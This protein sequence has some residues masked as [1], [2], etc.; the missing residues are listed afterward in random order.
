MQR[1]SASRSRRVEKRSR[2]SPLKTSCRVARLYGRARTSSSYNPSTLTNELVA[3]RAP[4][5]VRGYR[6][7]RRW[8]HGRGVSRARYQAQSRGRH[9]GSPG[10]R[11]TRSG[12]AGAVRTRGADARGAQSS[13]HRADLRDRGKRARDGAG[14]RRGS[15]G[16]SSRAGRCRSTR[17][18]RSRA[19]SPTRSKRRTNSA[20]ST[21]ISS[22][23]TSRS[24]PTAS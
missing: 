8:R 10:E 2:V 15:V 4:G 14:R 9:Q 22:P 19:R 17:C 16:A 3:R 13:P 24:R 21:A 1:E 23:P 11:R 18:S 6:S 7:A 12:P 5:V 20:S